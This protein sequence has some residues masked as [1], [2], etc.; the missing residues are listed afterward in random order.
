[1]NFFKVKLRI[2][3]KADGQNKCI[4]EEPLP[5]HEEPK[6]EN[7]GG[8]D[9]LCKSANSD[10]AAEAE[11]DDDDFITN[12]VKRRLKE[13]RKNSFM[14]LIPEEEEESCKDDDDN[15]VGEGETCSNEWRDVEAEGQ[16]WWRGF[17]AVFE[18]YCER[19]LFFDRMST[20][21][22]NEVCKGSLSPSIQSPRSASKKLAHPLRCL[23]SKQFGETDGETEHLQQPQNGPYQ[24]LE[25]AYVGQVC[26]TWEALHCQYSQMCQKVSWQ[27][28]NPICYNH[29]AQ[30]FQQFQVMLQRFIEN[31]P[32]EKGLRAEVY[33]RTR[34]TL[35]KLLHVPNVQGLDQG[36]TEDDSDMRVLAPDLIRI[37]ENS[38]LTFQLFL[39]RDKKKLSG[40]IS[41]H[42][43]QNQLTAHLQQVQ[44][45]L[46]KKAMKLKE[47]KR[48]KKGWK[49]WSWPQKQDDI[50][51]LMAL[52]DIK[53]LLR[54]IRMTRI[55][56]EQL[57][58][59]EE[60]MKKLNVTHNRLERDPCPILFPCQ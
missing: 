38:V 59:C 41:L 31:E 52:I 28:E 48:K 53:I 21:Q 15:D 60:K 2:T 37:M 7:G 18:K 29:S 19:M 12:E 14:V 9:D 11:D 5:E 16:Q 58:W 22:L 54:V 35:P 44:S 27:P 46:E 32:F 20:Q 26:L 49:K 33:A 13:L 45:S 3:Q 23:S 56:K 36:S 39:K 34:N 8:D 25:T 57:L 10:A 40:T 6:P 43:N 42:G 24:D 4:S 47:L 55:T 51:L 17:D 1:M 30:Q 50:Q